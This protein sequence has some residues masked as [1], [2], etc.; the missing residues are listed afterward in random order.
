MILNKRCGYIL[1]V[2]SLPIIPKN[3]DIQIY[4]KFKYRIKTRQFSVY[5]YTVLQQPSQILLVANITYV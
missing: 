2:S 3:I 5:R 4:Q 1:L